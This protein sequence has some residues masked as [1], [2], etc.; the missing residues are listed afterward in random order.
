MNFI[1]RLIAFATI[2]LLFYL[3]SNGWSVVASVYIRV[4]E[5]L[6]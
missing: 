1:S 2:A 5:V 3:F 4:T 6:R